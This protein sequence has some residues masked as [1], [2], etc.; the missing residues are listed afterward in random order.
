MLSS[1]PSADDNQR[2]DAKGRQE[3]R[4]LDPNGFTVMFDQLG[5]QVENGDA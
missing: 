2:S 4:P 3:N 5:E 1:Q